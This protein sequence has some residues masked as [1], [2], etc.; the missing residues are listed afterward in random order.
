[1]SH[2]ALAAITAFGLIGTLIGLTLW[3]NT[4]KPLPDHYGEKVYWEGVACG[5]QIE[6]NAA[7]TCNFT[8]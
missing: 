5:E 6:A 8:Q 2:K 7:A 1:V 3:L 4:P